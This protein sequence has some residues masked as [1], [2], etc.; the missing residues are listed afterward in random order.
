MNTFGKLFRI[1]IFGESHGSC[2][3]CTIDGLPAGFKP[4]L[5]S[6]R[7]ELMLRAPGSGIESTSRRETDDFRILSGF[8][9]DRCTGMPMTAVFC[10]TDARPGDYPSA[11]ARPSHADYAAHEKFKGFNDPRGG[12]AFSGG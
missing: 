10:N 12:G 7:N 6:V 2:I 5:E 3:G 8:Y 1:S 11:L 4:D 9:S